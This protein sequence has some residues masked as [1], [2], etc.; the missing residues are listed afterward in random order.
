MNETNIIGV[1]GYPASGKGEFAKIAQELC[2]PVVVMGDMIRR[3]VSKKGMELTDENIGNMA[4]Q[5]RAKHGNDAVALL[6]AKEVEKLSSNTIVID[7]IRGD[8]EIEYFKSVFPN[9]ILV[10]ISASFETRLARMKERGRT[11]D[12]ITAESLKA[13]D[14]R[15]EGFGLG[16]AMPMAGICIENESSRKAFEEK[17]R[18][19]LGAF[20]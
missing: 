13:R 9:F 12:T 17:I 14:E 5:L 10:C 4:K 3:E 16:R 7:G 20:T 15:E 2:I 1:V 18:T 6:T 8:S 19:Y 11:D